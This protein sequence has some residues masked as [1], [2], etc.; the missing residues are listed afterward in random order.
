MGGQLMHHRMAGTPLGPQFARLQRS[1]EEV[2]LKK[3]VFSAHGEYWYNLHLAIVNEDRWAETN[4]DVL[5]RLC[6]VI[7]GAARKHGDRLSRLA[8]LPDHDHLTL[9]CPIDRSPEAVALSY[10]NNGAYA[11][12]M[13]PV[14]MF[15]YYVGTFGEYDRGAVL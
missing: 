6:R 11:Y 4:D 3:P 5:E 15:S 8:I 2:D 9:G 14:F 1:Y 10:L 12:G 7:E 13:K